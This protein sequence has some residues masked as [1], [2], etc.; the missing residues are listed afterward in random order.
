MNVLFDS[1]C[2]VALLVRDHPFYDRAARGYLEFIDD[3]NTNYIST[4]TLSEVYRTITSGKSYLNFSHQ[5]AHL[6]IQKTVLQYFNLVDLNTEDYIHVLDR[7]KSLKLKGAIIYDAL[8][9]HAAFKVNALRLVTF[10]EKDFRKVAPEN[11][12]ELVVPL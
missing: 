7:M 12:A 11:G 2:L 1:S 8:I 4:H 6:I 3:E 5:K 9:S 10:N